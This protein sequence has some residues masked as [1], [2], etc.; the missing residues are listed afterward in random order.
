[1]DLTKLINPV[2]DSRFTVVSMQVGLLNRSH[3]LV[4]EIIVSL[5]L[6]RH[7][8]IYRYTIYVIHS[9]NLVMRLFFTLTS[10]STLTGCFKIW[11]L[12]ILFQKG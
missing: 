11:P 8:S 9:F 7:S 5:S 4:Q 2:V 6:S 1:M 3:N 10:K 12:F